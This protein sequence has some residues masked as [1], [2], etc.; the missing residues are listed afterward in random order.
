M[1]PEE[2]AARI[3]KA[4]AAQIWLSRSDVKTPANARS[5]HSVA[6]GSQ[7]GAV[8]RKMCNAHYIRS[9]SG[10]ASEVPLAYRSRNKSV[11][12]VCAEPMRGR[13]GWGMCPRHYKTARAQL[14][15]MV[16]VES[17]GGH[18]AECG[19]SFPLAVFDFHH[20]GRKIDAIARLIA[21]A[22]S[23]SIAREAV[24]CVLLCANCHRIK[25]FARET[26]RE[27]RIQKGA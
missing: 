14:I 26:E 6:V 4:I 5:Y 27:S 20:P 21:T 13:G 23:S 19:Q 16:L 1:T 11:C 25:H 8:A 7:R 10:R 15:K 22:S 24:T 17:F 3:E 2:L 18:C 9:R 12:H